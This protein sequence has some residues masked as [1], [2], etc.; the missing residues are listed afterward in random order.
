MPFKALLLTNQPTFSARVAT[1]LETELPAGDVLLRVSHSS[2]NYKDALA[3]SNRGPVV[4]AWPMVP[5]IDA[6]GVVETSTHARFRP[7]DVLMVQGWGLG[8]TR[9]GGLAQRVRL[10]GEW[11]LPVPAPFGAFEAAA[12]GTA[13][14]TAALCVQALLGHGL[15][16]TDGPVLVSGASGGVGSLA[17]LLLARNGFAVT[18]L[19]GK[20]TAWTYLET[21]GAAEV[22]HRD[23]FASP[24]KPLQKE[25]FAGVVDTL[26]SH[27][28]ANACAQVCRGGAVA[29]C[30]LAMDMDLPA[31]V[32]P[33]ILRGITLYGIDSVQTP[34]SRRQAAW[35]LLA[36]HVVPADLAG[37]CRTVGL[38]LAPLE[39]G[40]Q[41]AGEITG[42]IVVD[43][44]R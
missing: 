40:H 1:L 16:P 22:L 15:R 39:A 24:G 43:V 10:P 20:T 18:A 7:G 34:I 31:S 41:L 17:V 33:F 37:M 21:L 11:L 35:D 27:V 14:Y 25:R 3:L 32:A 8:E 23:G 12:L 5:G 13:G 4:R 28:L 42:R 6:A 19:S 29:A 9:W 30:G 38:T 2:L 44:N 26:G 36:R